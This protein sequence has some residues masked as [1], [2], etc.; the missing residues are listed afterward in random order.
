MPLPLSVDRPWWVSAFGPLYLTVYGHRDD[1]EARR[2]APS[3]VRLLGVP[4]H[5]R[6][7]DVACGEGR[8]SRA[9]SNLGY[10]VTGVDL[11]SALLDEAN[12]ASAGLPGAPAYVR[13]DMRSL[14]FS[15]QFEGAVSLFTSFGYF[16]DRGDD[17]RHLAA[18]ERALVP[19]GR[20]LLDFL[21]APQVRATL[22]SESEETRFPHLMKVRR[23]IDDGG[24]DGPFV[25]KEVDIEDA[26]TGRLL[27]SVSERVRLYEP[28]GIDRALLDAGFALVGE[29][30]GDLD[31]P[32]WTPSSRRCVRVAE[33]PRKAPYP[34]HA[35]R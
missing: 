2:F 30:F 6:I 27:A 7:L 14:P 15:Q 19:G 17:L 8:Y 9:L 10:R 28:D 3:I 11:S 13:G 34:P 20:F 16:D 31:G 4:P 24:L 35:P 32:P 1:D 29:R 25:R 23:R 21:N 26:R 12:A 18:I 5:A 22:V 33:R